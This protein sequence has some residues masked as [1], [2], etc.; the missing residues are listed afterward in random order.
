MQLMLWVRDEGFTD[1]DFRD[2]DIFQVW[3]DA[4]IPGN[5]EKARFL[6]IQ[7]PNYGGD[8]NELVASEY[9]PGPGADPVIRRMRKYRVDYAP[10]LDTETLAA[11]KDIESMVEPITGVFTLA[12]I[13]RK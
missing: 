9:A 7:V 5:L 4:W 13:S 2:G 3:D 1:G 8:Q 6:V 10:K 12:D 11:V